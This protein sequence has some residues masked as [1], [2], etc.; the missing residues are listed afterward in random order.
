M[1]T[2]FFRKPLRIIAGL[3]ACLLLPC[4]TT[5]WAQDNGARSKTLVVASFGGGLDQ[6]YKKVVEPFEKEYGVTIRWTP[7]SA[8]ENLAKLKATKAKPEYDIALVENFILYAGAVQ[9]LFEP[10]D[11]SI[12]TNYRDLYPQVRPLNNLGV[13]FG[14]FYQGIFY[15]QDEFAKRGWTA[16]EHWSD[17][18]EP[19]YCDQIGMLTPSVSDGLRFL[20]ILAEGQTKRMPEAIARLATLKKCIPVLE[21]SAPKLEEKV[22]LGE[23]TMGVMGSI[24][25]IPLMQRGYPIN[26]VL[27]SEGTVAG[28]SAA[29]AVKGAP[30]P[31][32]AQEFLNWFLRPESQQQLMKE[33]FYTPTNRLVTVPENM[34][35]L[36]ILDSEGIKGL[37]PV[38]E[39]AIYKNRAAWI[40]QTERA[41]AQ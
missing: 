18:F 7:S 26:F 25:A 3:A 14:L 8:A 4:H 15:R 39:E 32:M 37:V 9:G 27:P 24:R 13:P 11:E 30:N 29:A 38:D 22:Q 2:L 6:V 5:A 36:G 31:K 23:Y 19:R 1:S 41:M 12:V 28:Y 17:L 20:L 35:K 34:K 40:R 21:P 10:V 33:L 16:P